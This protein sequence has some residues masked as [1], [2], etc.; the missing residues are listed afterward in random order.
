M[1]KVK[2]NSPPKQRSPAPTTLIDSRIA[3]IK[4]RI[5]TLSLRLSVLEAKRLLLQDRPLR[6][7]VSRRAAPPSTPKRRR[8]RAR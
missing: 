7:V 2:T 4:A 6:R 3:D 1:A 5:H 8:K